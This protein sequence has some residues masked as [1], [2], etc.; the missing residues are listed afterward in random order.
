MWQQNPFER[1]SKG[2]AWCYEISSWH[3]VESGGGDVHSSPSSCH[4]QLAVQMTL[5]FTRNF[6]FICLQWK[7]F[8]LILEMSI[9]F[10]HLHKIGAQFP[11][12][13]HLRALIYS[14]STSILDNKPLLCEVG[15]FDTLSDWIQCLNFA[16][17][18][19]IQYSIQYCFTQ[20]S[21]QNIIQ[22]KKIRRFN[23]KDN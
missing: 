13:Q 21:I 2:N 10:C 6:V 1:E 15:V 19:F 5:D 23:S 16:K 14:L 12:R 20:D 8:E 11:C 22:L 3:L 9:L 18:W 7:G 17:K 4:H